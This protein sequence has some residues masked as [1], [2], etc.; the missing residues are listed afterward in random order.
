[1]YSIRNHL[2]KKTSV[3]HPPL[4]TLYSLCPHSLPLLSLR[5]VIPIIVRPPKRLP[6]SHGLKLNQT[7]KFNV[8]LYTTAFASTS[9]IV[10]RTALQ[11]TNPP[12]S[13]TQFLAVLPIDKISDPCLCPQRFLPHT[14]H[15]SSYSILTAKTCILHMRHTITSPHPLSSP[16]ATLACSA[17]LRIS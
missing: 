14:F 8:Q 1:M 5:L 15:I 7:D 3:C 6:H 4:S 10:N 11:G 12:R 9:F 16:C 13:E 2:D 17:R